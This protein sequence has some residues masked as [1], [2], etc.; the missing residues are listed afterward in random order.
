MKNCILCSH[1]TSLRSI[2]SLE[3]KF[4]ERYISLFFF[5]FG[6][7]VGVEDAYSLVAFANLQVL[8]VGFF[9]FLIL[10][11]YRVVCGILLVL[12]GIKDLEARY[13]LF[14][15]MNYCQKKK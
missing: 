7:G 8:V 9:F 10:R 4:R 6:G 11:Y 15:L 14:V 1:F 2:F 13:M 3:Y 5:F 12:I